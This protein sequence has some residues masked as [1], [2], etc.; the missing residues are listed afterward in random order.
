MAPLRGPGERVG[1]LG[2]GYQPAMVG[3]Q[4]VAQYAHAAAAAVLGQSF[5]IEPP[6][7]VNQEDILAVITPLG[8]VVRDALRH[9]TS[10][11][12]HSRRHYRTA[13]SKVQIQSS[14]S[15]PELPSPNSPVP[16][17]PPEL[18]PSSR[19]RRSG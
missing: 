4:A 8:D 13:G 16:E 9:H 7:F 1:A 14:G 15:V 5:Q 6:V 19:D 2:H 18:P 3:H 11:P 10:R 17:L 12:W